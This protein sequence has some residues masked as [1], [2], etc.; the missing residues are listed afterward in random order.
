ME[1]MAQRSTMTVLQYAIAATILCASLV[2]GQIYRWTDD[3]GQVHLTDNPSHIPPKHRTDTTVYGMTTPPVPE[4]SASP[5]AQAPEPLSAPPSQ[6]SAAA[7][8][9]D[10]LGRGPEYWRALAR[11]WTTELQQHTAE[12]DRLQLLYDYT[13]DLAN[14]TRDVWDRGRLEAEVERLGK[15]LADIAQRLVQ[16]RTMLQTTLPLEA[17]Q[18]GANPEWLREPTPPAR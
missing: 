12:R 3:T 9:R 16:A 7:E 8:P 13:R 6:S 17:T 15:A 4:V 11:Q 18:L 1:L 10:R 14:A 5:D 2:W